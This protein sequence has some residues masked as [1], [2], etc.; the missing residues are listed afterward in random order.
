MNILFFLLLFIFILPHFHEGVFLHCRRTPIESTH[1]KGNACKYIHNTFFFNSKEYKK[2]Q[3]W[4]QYF[5]IEIFRAFHDQL[6][7]GVQK[8]TKPCHYYLCT[9]N[10]TL[11]FQ[12]EC[13][14][15]TKMTF[16]FLCRWHTKLS[17]E[18]SQKQKQ[19]HKLKTG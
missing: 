18:S 1:T 9:L 3:G 17:I 11:D 19:C 10:L 6:Q 2:L 8:I 15:Y 5:F 13:C 4:K 7:S 14:T 16:N 12:I